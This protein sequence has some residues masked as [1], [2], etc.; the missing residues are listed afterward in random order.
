MNN[1][2]VPITGIGTA[3]PPLVPLVPLVCTTD[4]MPCCKSTTTSGEWNFPN[5]SRVPIM[6]TA[7]SFYRNRGDSGEVNLFR[8]NSDV[9]APTGTF[10]CVVPD[11]T[12]TNQTV[13][14]NIGEMCS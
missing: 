7:T 13:C 4:R 12:G 2:Y 9:M 5:G 3:S 10:C 8:L 11:A 6:N 1:S 14:A